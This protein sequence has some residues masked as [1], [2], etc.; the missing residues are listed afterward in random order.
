MRN[1]QVAARINDHDRKRLQ[2]YA[3]VLDVSE[4]QIIREGLRDK[5]DKLEEENPRIV[6][7]IARRRAPEVE[8][9]I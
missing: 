9:A 4:A 8:W 5:L 2:E 3:A 1:T 7:F 6:S